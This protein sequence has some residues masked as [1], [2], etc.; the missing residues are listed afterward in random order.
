ML[1]R[2]LIG[3]I[4]AAA[5]AGCSGDN[6]LRCETPDRYAGARSVPPV[7]VPDGLTV[8]DETNSLRLPP[9]PTGADSAAARCLEAPPDFFENR[10]VG[11]APEPAP[12]PDVTEDP[13]RRIDN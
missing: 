13:E 7:R 10:N 4:V 11:G 2:L 9:Q 5:L 3:A 12:A 1:Q 6:E 8:P